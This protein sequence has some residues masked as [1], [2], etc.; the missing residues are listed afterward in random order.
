MQ[1]L[2]KS[3]WP[4]NWGP[5]WGKMN[6]LR[7]Q[8]WIIKH[9]D[10]CCW[11]TAS[12]AGYACAVQLGCL[13]KANHSPTWS[14]CLLTVVNYP[15]SL[16]SEHENP[17]HR[18]NIMLSIEP[19]SVIYYFLHNYLVQKIYSHCGTFL[20]T[21]NG[22]ARGFWVLFSCWK[23]KPKYAI[24]CHSLSYSPKWETISFQ[25]HTE[26]YGLSKPINQIVSN[27]THVS[28]K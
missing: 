10:S 24:P 16:H 4:H 13:W 6:R 22:I 3:A 8:A 9:I 2:N 28:H 18:K 11:V 5:D 27:N 15:I 17:W 25:E 1:E 12:F 19:H 20:C 21:V 7:S 26:A 23:P 14:T